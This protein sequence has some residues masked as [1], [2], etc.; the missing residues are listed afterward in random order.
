MY[1]LPLWL[2]GFFLILVGAV[3]DLVAF[4]LAPQSMLA[5]LAALTL[6]WNMVCFVSQGSCRDTQPD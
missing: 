6:V 4:G 5:P 3:L 1:Q 2:I